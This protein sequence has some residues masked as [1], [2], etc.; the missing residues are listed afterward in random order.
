MYSQNQLN[1]QLMHPSTFLFSL[2]ALCI[3]TYGLM[4]QPN[5]NA[6]KNKMTPNGLDAMVLIP[7]GSFQMGYSDDEGFKLTGKPMNVNSFYHGA[8]NLV[9]TE[10]R[11][12]PFRVGF[13]NNETIFTIVFPRFGFD[14]RL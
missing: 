2:Y 13:C 6:S 11:G 9:V 1:P 8:K 3:A 7:G 14:W 5:T 4:P 10:I 12:V